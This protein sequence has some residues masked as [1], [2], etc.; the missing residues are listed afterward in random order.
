ML[1]VAGTIFWTI[2]V[3]LQLLW[4]PSTS[5][6]EIIGFLELNSLGIGFNLQTS[7]LSAKPSARSADKVQHSSRPSQ[8]LKTKTE[9]W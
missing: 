6:G 1:Q 9:A 3:A 7:K 2:G 4:K 8:P 5:L